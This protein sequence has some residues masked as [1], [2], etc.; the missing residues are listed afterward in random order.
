M[1]KLVNYMEYLFKKKGFFVIQ[2]IYK[3]KYIPRGCPKYSKVKL[4]LIKFNSN[5]NYLFYNVFGCK[6][7]DNRYNK[8]INIMK[9]DFNK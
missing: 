8:S 3:N 1:T 4:N 5:P 6:H 9:I 2:N 7:L